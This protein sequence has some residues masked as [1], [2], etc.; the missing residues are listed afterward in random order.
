VKSVDANLEKGVA[1]DA[2]RG[3]S[4]IS[5]QLGLVGKRADMSA[6]FSKGEHTHIPGP[7][8]VGGRL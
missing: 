6:S 5:E 8:L 7:P 1:I 4:V 3:I 2:L